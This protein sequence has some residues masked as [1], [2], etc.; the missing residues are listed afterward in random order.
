MSDR[1]KEP[2][3]TD[4][5]RTGRAFISPCCTAGVYE[6]LVDG[7]LWLAGTVAGHGWDKPRPGNIDEINDDG[8]KVYADG[9]ECRVF[10]QAERNEQKDR[11][12]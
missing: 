2:P 11:K 6:F 4:T 7:T 12:A 1:T 5:T 3:F 8:T 10:W 9:T